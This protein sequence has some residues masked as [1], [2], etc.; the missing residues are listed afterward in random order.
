[1]ELVNDALASGWISSAGKYLD[2]FEERWAA[3]CGMPFGIA[4]SNG[5]TALDIAV[6]LLGLEAGDEVIM[7]T[8]TIISPAQ[9]VVRGGGKPVLVDSDPITWQMD[10]SQI[11]SKITSRT[12]AIVV[13]HIYG[14]PADMDPI[15]ALAEKYSLTVIEDAAEVHGATYKGRPCGSIGHISTF[16]FYANKLVTTGEGGMVLVKSREHAERARSL[17]NLC[18]QLSRRFYHESLG[19]NYRMTNLQAAMGVGQLERLHDTIDRKRDIAHAYNASFAEI[20]AVQLPV[21]M[22]WAHAVYWVYGIVLTDERSEDAV[23]VMALMRERGV[24]TRPFFLGM[25]EQPVFNRMGLFCDERYPVAERLARRGVY[26]P[27]GLTMTAG[28]LSLV[29]DAVKECLS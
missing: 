6:N 21:E 24:E 8:F 9:S 23:R 12:R 19:Y 28:Q 26:I 1:M 3:Y 5:S 22:P 2:L 13:V 20:P 18:F 17:R 27:N 4:V 10:T 29:A 11:E 14:H 7:P 25:H 16:S 15:M